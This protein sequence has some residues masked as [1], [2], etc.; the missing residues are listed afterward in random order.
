IQTTRPFRI[1]HS[2]RM[3][4]TPSA[5][6]LQARALSRDFCP[7]RALDDFNLSLKAG[8]ILGLLGPNGAGKT[9]T[10]RLLTGALAPTRGQITICGHNLRTRPYAV[11]YCLGYLPDRPPLYPELTVN[12]YLH[13]CARLHRIARRQRAAA[14]ASARAD[15]DLDT[16]GKRLIGNLS[17]GYQQR[18]GIAQ[19]IIHRPQIVILDEPTA[20]LDPHQ[21]RQIRTLITH[22]ADTHAVILSSHILTE[23][24]AMASRVMLIHRGRVALDT[25]MAELGRHADETIRLGLTHGPGRSRLEAIAGVAAAVPIGHGL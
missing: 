11:K 24:Q 22:L 7:I 9:T 14:V 25:R 3:T 2:K 13:F 8:E 5:A 12:E 1:S 18:V 16:V 4:N 23:I 15:C 21:I 10:L 19:A 17:K 6:L 20:G